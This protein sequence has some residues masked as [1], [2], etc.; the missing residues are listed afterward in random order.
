MLI[1][2]KFFVFFDIKKR[3]FKNF[4]LGVKK[5]QENSSNAHHGEVNVT[6]MVLLMSF[7]YLIGNVPNS[8]SPILFTANVDSL[9]YSDYVIFGNFTLFLSHGSSFFLYLFFNKNFYETFIKLVVRKRDTKIKRNFLL[10]L[11]N[12]KTFFFPKSEIRNYFE[13]SY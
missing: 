9:V 8:I 11:F 7:F 1:L 2:V 4:F 13:L 5:K 3:G 12:T 6:K 10:F